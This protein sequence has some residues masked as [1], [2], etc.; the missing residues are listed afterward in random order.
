MYSKDDKALYQW[1]YKRLQVRML[2]IQY[3]IRLLMK[4]FQSKKVSDPRLG[5][6]SDKME[7]LR[8]ENRAS[9]VNFPN[10]ERQGLLRHE[11]KSCRKMGHARTSDSIGSIEP[12][13]IGV[14]AMPPIQ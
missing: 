4:I 14:W 7:F 8:P 6:G 9:R 5:V 10:E 11:K 3:F 12:W 1:S 2:G 13:M